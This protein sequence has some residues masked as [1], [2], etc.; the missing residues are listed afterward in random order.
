MHSHRIGPDRK[1]PP[2]LVRQP[3]PSDAITRPPKP[4]RYRTRGLRLP[5]YEVE[6]RGGCV[7]LWLIRARE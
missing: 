4:R 5:R 6:H 7:V 2:P 3:V 1:A